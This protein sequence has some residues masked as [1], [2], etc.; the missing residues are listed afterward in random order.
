MNQINPETYALTARCPIDDA[1]RLRSLARS[2][3]LT[4]SAF[5]ARLIHAAVNGIGFVPE[6]PDW[7]NRR[8]QVNCRRRTLQDER[9]HRGD[10]RK[11]GWE[12][13]PSHQPQLTSKQ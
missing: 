13:L 4:P 10:Y 3:G 5:V 6:D 12:I 11:P 8:R 9:T 1:A 2:Q 7:V